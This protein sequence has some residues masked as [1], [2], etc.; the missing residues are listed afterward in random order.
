MEASPGSHV[1]AVSYSGPA[2]RPETLSKKRWAILDTLFGGRR[3]QGR[4]PLLVVGLGNPGERYEG[5]RHNVGQW[6]LDR[7]ASEGSIS[8]SRRRRLAVVGQGE[9]AGRPVVLARPRTFVND[10]GRAVTSLLARYRAAAAD[11]LVIHDD[12]DLPPGKVRLRP[13]GG[14]GGHKGMRSI[15]DAVG[16]QEFAR[17]RIGIGR[18]STVEDEIEHVLGTM[19]A[20]DRS[21]VDSAVERAAQAVVCILA[22]GIDVAMSRFN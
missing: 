17:L 1:V 10:S 13:S 18:P 12:M 11:L 4:L 20:Q 7:V 19:S 6:C 8:I 15:I 22:E 9:I 16:T 14:S 21:L 5:T 3:R 2:G